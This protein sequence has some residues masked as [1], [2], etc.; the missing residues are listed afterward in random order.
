MRTRTRVV[1]T[2]LGV[3]SPLGCTVSE[4]WEGLVS[5]RS[6]VGRISSFDPS[7]YPAQ[8]AAHV[9]SFDPL[10]Y[11]DAKEARRMA[12]FSQFA[13]A[14]TRVA[15]EDARVKIGPDN[16]ADV[17]VFLGTGIGGLA[18]IEQECRTLVARGGS[19]ISPFF[20]PSMLPNM[21]AA[22]VS[23]VFGAKGYSSTAITACAA[24]TQAIG[25]AAEVIRR[26][27]AH[28]MIAGGTEAPLCEIGLAGFA[29][30]RALTTRNEEPTKA[31]RPFD[32]TRDGFVPAE[33]A[34]ILI[35]EELG[36]AIRR[37]APILAEVVGYGCSSDAYHLVMPEPEGE[38]AA[39]AIEAALADAEL[40]PADVDYI[41]AHGTSTPL[42][43][44]TET[45]AI[46]RVFGERAYQVPISSTKSMI[47]HLLGAAGA[48]EAIACIMSLRD[49]IVHPTI[50]YETPDPACDLD[51]VP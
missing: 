35:L 43:D 6:G 47:G 34:G 25:E 50:N 7:A 49:G 8:L 51:Y 16:A 12:R 24:G 15:L 45:R 1:V 13:V 37:N 22:Q 40:A 9:W 2:G 46:K 11:I 38:G 27:V 48:V 32:L 26:G 17:G 42:N 31:S 20:V 23:R 19:R 10:D 39:S 21:A 3:M 29:I 14:A 28:T 36:H 5:G 30:M 44:A 41:N 33:G 18:N 4:Y